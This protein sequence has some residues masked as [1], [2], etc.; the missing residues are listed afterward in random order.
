MRGDNTDARGL[1]ADLRTLGVDLRS[2]LAI[3]IGAGGAAASAILALSRMGAARI[4]IANRTRSR[5]VSLVRRF[6]SPQ[7]SRRVELTACGLDALTDAVTS[8]RR[9]AGAEC[10]LDGPNDRGFRAAGLCRDRAANAFSTMPSIAPRRRPFLREAIALGRPNADGAGM[11]I[12]QGELAF[13]LFNHVA[14]PAGVMRQA[15]L[16][17]LG[18]A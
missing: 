13:E 3:V 18:R 8:G 9:R 5:A 2:R 11:L 14:P 16:E 15:L 17:R 6:H 12:N 7:S 4:V 1:E 10:D